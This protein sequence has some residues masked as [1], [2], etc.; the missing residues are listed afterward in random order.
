MASL[1]GY[2]I[3]DLAE[4]EIFTAITRAAAEVCS[5]PMASLSLRDEARQWF[6][7]R[8]GFS[9]KSS[10]NGQHPFAIK[11]ALNTCLA[12]HPRATRDANFRFYAGM[13][14]IVPGGNT[15]SALCLLGNVPVRLTAEQ[16]QT[17]NLL[18]DSARRVINLRRNLGLA[19]YAKAVDMTSDGVTL[20]APSSSGTTIIYANESFLRFTGYEFHEAIGQSGTFPTPADCHAVSEALEEATRKRQMT[21]V[22][23]KFRKKDGSMVWDRISFLPYVDEHRKVVYLVAVHRDI[24]YQ[25]EAEV[26]AQQLHAMRTTLA[27]VDH[28]VKNFMNT[29]QL[30]SLQAASGKSID[31]KTQQAFDAALQSTRR[32]LAAIHGMSVFRDRATP[33]GVSLLDHEDRR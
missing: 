11:E 33:F 10:G 22:E 3:L 32:Q 1:R 15:S 28:V 24:S 31:V 5:T 9:G 13:P 19:V 20:A 6:E 18:A 17:L 23:C 30:Y 21:T 26:Q 25:K 2:D 4:E 16:A 14:L 27:T 12:D 29:A 8:V 7:T